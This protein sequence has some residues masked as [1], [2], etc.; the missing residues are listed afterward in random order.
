MRLLS[1]HVRW[2]TRS[3]R[4]VPC[5]C[6][7]VGNGHV[8]RPLLDSLRVQDSSELID[9]DPGHGPGVIDDKAQ[10]NVDVVHHE[11]CLGSRCECPPTFNSIKST[12]RQYSQYLLV[13][14][15]IKIV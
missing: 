10:P 5:R 4:L 13:F 12:K 9:V 15:S 8:G 2:A 3:L 11:H 6:R 14:R 1:S 7:S